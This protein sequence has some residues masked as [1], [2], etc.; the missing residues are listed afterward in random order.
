MLF[1]VNEDWL[2]EDLIY[3]TP[4]KY[5]I[6]D[7]EPKIDIESNFIIDYCVELEELLKYPGYGIYLT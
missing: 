1:N 4:T 2:A 5:P 6:I 3:T 7:I